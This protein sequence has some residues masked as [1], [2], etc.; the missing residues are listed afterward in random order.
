MIDTTKTAPNKKTE[1]VELGKKRLA[2]ATSLTQPDTVRKVK[3]LNDGT[4]KNIEVQVKPKKPAKKPT[5]FKLGK[6][7]PD[8]EIV[9][10]ENDMEDPSKHPIYDCCLACNRANVFRAINNND[11]ALFKTLL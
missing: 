6:W 4:T 5:V 1:K 7:N 9:E 3:K 10:V 2:P 11:L 8:T